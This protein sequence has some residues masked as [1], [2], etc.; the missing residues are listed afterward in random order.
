[1]IGIPPVR[2]SR[3][4]SFRDEEQI[5]D[6]MGKFASDGEK[7]IGVELIKTYPVTSLCGA[8]RSSFG[9]W[10]PIAAALRHAARTTAP[11]VV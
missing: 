6:A 10:K 1:M 11:V 5:H 7:G 3:R 2:I 9:S 4:N 8:R